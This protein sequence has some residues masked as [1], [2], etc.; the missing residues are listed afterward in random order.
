[1]K[2]TRQVMRAAKEVYS[3]AHHGYSQAEEYM[4][5]K[6]TAIAHRSG[7]GARDETE[8]SNFST[9]K[10]YRIWTGRVQR[11]AKRKQKTESETESGVRIRKQLG[12]C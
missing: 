12:P 1:M 10:T 6:E 4:S 2:K 8:W 7:K 11:D 9:K 3:I 5:A